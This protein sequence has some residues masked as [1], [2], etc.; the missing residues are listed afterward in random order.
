[1]VAK[2][3]D[4]R[5]PAAPERL[6]DTT[7]DDRERDPAGLA[8]IAK[9][10]AVITTLE[11]RGELSS[12]EIAELIGE[13][14][15]SVY[16]LLQSLIGIGWIDRGWRR[17]TYR[18]GLLLLTVGSRLEDHIDIRECALPTLRRLLD[19]IGVTSF[20]C[21]RREARAVCVER[22]EG[23][24]VQSLA[25]Q[26]GSSLPLYA[27]AAPR[28]LLAFLPAAEQHAILKVR[29]GQAGDPPRPDSAVIAADVDEV[30]RRGY[31]V[32]DGDVTPGIAALGAPVFNHRGE[33][34]AAISISG[35]R[36]QILGAQESR[37]VDLI[38][39]GADE[40]SR[41]LGWQAVS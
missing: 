38:I 20:L 27:G 30:R 10:G 34:A 16:R 3:V 24:A 17:G 7:M 5:R 32:S 29:T 26:L 33:L 4:S 6:S 41:A 37:N 22:L 28:S 13:P 1:M 15:S 21:V 18:L 8:L 40:V 9:A 25:M 11:R 14:L 2:T 31:A 23:Q 35:L 19:E 39:A 12:A 36:S